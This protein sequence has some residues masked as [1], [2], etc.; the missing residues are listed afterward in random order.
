MSGTFLSLSSEQ[1]NHLPLSFRNPSRVLTQSSAPPSPNFCHFTCLR[2]C[3][4][5]P[6]VTRLT[7]EGSP[8]VRMFQGVG[9]AWESWISQRQPGTGSGRMGKPGGDERSVLLCRLSAASEETAAASA[10]SGRQ[11]RR[12]GQQSLTAVYSSL[13]TRAEPLPSVGGQSYWAP[14]GCLQSRSL[15]HI[16]LSFAPLSSWVVS[17]PATNSPPPTLS[18]V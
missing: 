14:T 13:A 17:T 9:L 1:G 10:V 3:G 6:A 11:Q 2:E 16:L 4:H 18:R 12:L 15:A 5:S 7:P 8:G